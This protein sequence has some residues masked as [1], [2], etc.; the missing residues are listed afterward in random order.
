MIAVVLAMINLLVIAA[1]VLT[2]EIKPGPPQNFVGRDIALWFGTTI[3]AAVYMMLWMAG[4]LT[5]ARVPYVPARGAAVPAGVVAGLSGGCGV[6]SLGIMAIGILTIQQGNLNGAG[7]VVLGAI[8]LMPAGLG[9]AVAEVMGLWSQVQMADG[10][11]DRTFGR[12][13]RILFAGTAIGGTLGACGMCCTVFAM[14]SAAQQQAQQQQA[15]QQAQ[16]QQP[17]Q[18][19][20]PAEKAAEP[21]AKDEGPPTGKNVPPAK[22]GAIGEKKDPKNELKNP[23]KKEEAKDEKKE[24]APAAVNAGPAANQPPPDPAQVKAVTYA[25]A[26]FGMFLALVYAGLSIACFQAGRRAIRREVTRLIG[27]P[28]DHHADGHF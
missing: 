16:Q 3:V 19:G 2:D 17:K 7:F 20:L 10:L 12:L 14:I 24:Q 23:A 9:Y 1:F 4:R 27:D 15:Q 13:S 22:G 21:G 26:I 18:P 11:R 5:C 6:L 8:G 28:H 25:M